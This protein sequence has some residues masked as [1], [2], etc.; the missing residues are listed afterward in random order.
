VDCDQL[1]PN[2]KINIKAR[3]VT[4]TKNTNF[5]ILTSS[6]DCE[7]D[8]EGIIKDGFLKSDRSIYVQNLLV[9]IKISSMTELLKPRTQLSF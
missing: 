2:P 5:L 8:I 7:L 6:L 1:Y 9:R 3:P 4:V